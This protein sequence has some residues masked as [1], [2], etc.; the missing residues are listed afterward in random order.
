MISC[1][2]YLPNIL[3]IRDHSCFP[4][5]SS[6]CQRWW[7]RFLRTMGKWAQVFLALQWMFEQKYPAIFQLFVAG[8]YQRTTSRMKM[9]NGSVKQNFLDVSL[10]S[11]SYKKM[12]R[13]GMSGIAWEVG[14]WI[15]PGGNDSWCKESLNI[16]FYEG[17]R[18]FCKNFNNSIL[19]KYRVV[20][21]QSRQIFLLGPAEAKRTI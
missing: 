1:I 19:Y 12:E 18:V 14:S 17:M 10:S 15:T 2:R 3:E 6:G 16:P 9:R 7:L 11:H 21:C 8:F 13:S 4:L 5:V 20:L